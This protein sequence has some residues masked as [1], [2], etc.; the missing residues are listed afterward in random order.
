MSRPLE[1]ELLV[2]PEPGCRH[3]GKVPIKGAASQM[4]GY[5]RGAM[6]DNHPKRRM[7]LVRF[8]E[9]S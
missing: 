2:C 5:C 6:N 9:A 4:K 3:V 1:V 7:E 8:V